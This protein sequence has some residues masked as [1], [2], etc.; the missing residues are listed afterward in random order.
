MLEQILWITN[1]DNLERNRMGIDEEE[2]TFK[3]RQ[4]L[5]G[6]CSPRPMK[7]QRYFKNK[8]ILRTGIR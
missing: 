8:D 3:W 2:S 1:E 7:L 4:I 6:Q 5:K